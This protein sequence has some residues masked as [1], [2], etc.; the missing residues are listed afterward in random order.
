[1]FISANSVNLILIFLRGIKSI[2]MKKL[3]FIIIYLLSASL[4]AQITVTTVTS[5]FKGSGGISIDDDGS[6]YIADFGDFLG[7]ADP[8]G[9]PNH[10]MKLD[11]DLNLTQYSTGFIGASGNGFDS[12]GVLYQSD[13]RDN[14]IYKIVGGVRTF[15]TADGIV[16]PVGIVFDSQDNFFV[17]NCGDGTIRKVTPAGVSTQFASGTEFACPNGI[18][19][20]ENDNLYVSNFSNPNIVKIT[21]TGNISVIGNTIVGNGHLDY[22]I[23]TRNLYIASYSGHQIF[24]LNIDSLERNDIAG[25]GVRGNDDGPGDDATFSTPNGVAVSDNGDQIYINCAVPLSGSIINPQIVRL[26]SGVLSIAE[27]N[28]ASYNAIAYPNPASEQVTIE[29]DFSSEYSDLSIKVFDILGHLL[30]EAKDISSKGN[31][32]KETI[33]ISKLSAGSYLYTV[34]SNSRQLFNGKILKN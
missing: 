28:T 4:F 3:Q 8:D 31:H 33:N 21:P 13:I 16:S 26:I 9:L 6:L 23:N 29:A 20:D 32:F 12:N 24:S 5:S 34:N 2:A 22:D 19:V 17:C 15:V 10:V 11:T 18:T 1:M 27:N 7:I 25:T 30:M 14:A